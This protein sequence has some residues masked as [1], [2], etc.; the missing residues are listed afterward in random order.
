MRRCPHAG[1]IQYCPLYIASHEGGG[2][3][4]AHGYIDQE[5]CAVDLGEMNYSE[6]LGKLQGKNPKLVAQAEWNRQKAKMTEQR[7]RNMRINGIH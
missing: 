3:G 2:L 4:C 7:A 6:A 5:G 1:E